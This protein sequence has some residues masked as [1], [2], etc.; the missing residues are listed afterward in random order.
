MD[1]LTTIALVGIALITFAGI[2]YAIG[3]WQSRH[4]RLLDRVRDDLRDRRESLRRAAATEYRDRER[5]D[6]W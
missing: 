2:Y 6:R 5:G 4:D 3:K 1:L